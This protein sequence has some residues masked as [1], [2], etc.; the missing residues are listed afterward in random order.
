[1]RRALCCRFTF[2]KCPNG[3]GLKIRGSDVGVGQNPNDDSGIE[4]NP[5]DDVGVDDWS[6]SLI[7]V[8]V[9]VGV[10]IGVGIGPNGDFCVD[11][12]CGGSV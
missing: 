11:V 3:E 2:G 4:S 6:V 8:G 5:N 9:G 10:G 7:G 12:D 1:L